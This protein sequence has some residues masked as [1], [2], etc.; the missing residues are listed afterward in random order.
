MATR[1]ATR[2]QSSAGTRRGARPGGSRRTFC[3]AN[4]LAERARNVSDKSGQGTVVRWRV[5]EQ[6]RQPARL[7]VFVSLSLSPERTA[8]MYRVQCCRPCVGQGC[9]KLR[10]SRNAG[11]TF[12]RR[13]ALQLITPTSFSMDGLAASGASVQ[14]SGNTCRQ[15]L[16]IRAHRPPGR[17]YTFFR[18][19]GARL[20][21]L[22]ALRPCSPRLHGE[23]PRTEK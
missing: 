8:G 17:K 3:G 21:A 5:R 10:A 4:D 13:R 15:H 7:R 23:P 9:C 18:E 1:T 2:R 20:S 14:Q 22:G 16:Y 12:D 6:V 19:K 11:S